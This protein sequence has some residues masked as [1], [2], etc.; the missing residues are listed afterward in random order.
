[1]N[2]LSRFFEKEPTRPVESWARKM[3][4]PENTLPNISL[5]KPNPKRMRSIILNGNK[6]GVACINADPPYCF[7]RIQIDRNKNLELPKGCGLAT[8]LWVIEEHLNN[9]KSFGTDKYWSTSESA[10]KIWKLLARSGVAIINKDF[11]QIAENE[12]RG[13]YRVYPLQK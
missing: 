8:Y 11:E 5:S 1:M 10:V 3:I 6:I 9:G 7:A 13:D 12:Y 2:L 4:D